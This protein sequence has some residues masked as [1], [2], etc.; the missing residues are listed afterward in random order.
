MILIAHRGN[1][2]GPIPELENNPDYIQ[3]ALGLGFDVEVD[4]WTVDGKFFLGH[5]NPVYPISRSFL[6]NQKLWVHC[7]NPE[8]L[9][10]LKF[11]NIN[12][13]FH[14]TDK[15]TLTSKQ[16]IWAFPGTQPIKNSIAVMPELFNDNIS[17]CLGVCSDYI[18]NYKGTE[19][20]NN[21]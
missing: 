13:F 1:V 14:E 11:E 3:Q 9:Y 15:V 19:Y 6:K 4:L 16:F 2:D 20:E 21:L 18:T 10:A 17:Q 12:Y 5:D 8:G 7:K